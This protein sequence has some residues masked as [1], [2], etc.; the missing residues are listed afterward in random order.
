[1]PYWLIASSHWKLF[2]SYFLL[3]N[4]ERLTL[5]CLCQGDYEALLQ[6]VSH[7][8]IYE[9]VA[10]IPRLNLEAFTTSWIQRSIYQNHEVILGVD[11]REHGLIGQVALHFQQ[12]MTQQAELGYWLHPTF[13]GKGLMSEACRTL[14]DYAN[15]ALNIKEVIAT[16]DINNRASQRLLQGLGMQQIDTIILQ[17]AEG[18]P[19]QSFKFSRSLI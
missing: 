4:S 8:T 6:Q 9:A 5:R 18:L 2:W 3:L 11:A 16:C 14:L 17:T 13:H 19:R 10:I 12:E 1:V 15:T 7:P